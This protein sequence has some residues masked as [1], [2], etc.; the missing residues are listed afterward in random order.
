MANAKNEYLLQYDYLCRNGG[1]FIKKNVEMADSSMK[2]LSVEALIPGGNQYAGFLPLRMEEISF[3]PSGETYRYKLGGEYYAK[4]VV[5]DL[6]AWK[7]SLKD[8]NR[9][10]ALSGVEAQDALPTFH[11]SEKCDHTL[12]VFLKGCICFVD[13]LSGAVIRKI[14]IGDDW[15]NFLFNE[16]KGLFSFTSGNALH[17][18]DYEGKTQLVYR[19]EC[20]DVLSGAVPSRDEFGIGQGAYW[21]PDGGKLAFYIVDQSKISAYPLVRIQDPVAELEMIKYPV[22]GSKSETVRLAVY[23]LATGTIVRL[24]PSEW[25]ESY[26]TCV[27]W[28]PD[29]GHLYSMEVHRSQKYCRLRSYSAVNGQLE[30]TLFDEKDDKYVEPQH[31]LFFLPDG[32]FVWQSRR[33]GYNHLYL[34][35]ATG[36]LVRQLTKGSFEV[37]KLCGYLDE[38]DELLLLSTFSS[39]LNRDLCAVRVSDASFRRISKDGGT[40]SVAVSPKSGYFIDSFSSSE[41][42]GCAVLRNL[43]G[44]NGRLLN[45]AANPYE[46]YE[47]PVVEIGSFERGGDEI[48]YRIV[49][50]SRMEHGKRYPLAYYVYGG[51]HVQLIRNEWGAGMKGFEQM[52]ALN[53]YVVMSIDPHGSDNRGKAFEQRIWRNIGAVQMED[54]RYS[55]EW[56]LRK[57]SYVDSNRMG[58]YGWSFGGFMAMRLMLR[59][60]WLFALGVAGGPVV[61]WSFYE[62]MYTERYMGKPTEN[63]DGFAENNM[64]RYVENLSGDLLLVHCDNDPVVLWQNTLSFLQAAVSA[65]RQVDYAV[66]PG[67]KHNVQGPDRVHLML[68]IKHYFD[69]HFI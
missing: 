51:P 49:R 15:K 48:F 68:K 32:H 43:K 14:N 55:I 60:P 69:R 31:P 12:Y 56:L 19:E 33:D 22:A 42:P 3:L 37:T 58:V 18:L 34:Y 16:E 11:F 26:L 29:A 23:D 2:Q 50:P 64:R 10:L 52:M 1:G 67:H 8:F 65:A 30:R 38:T 7:V 59:S 27:T 47:V 39:P 9:M 5:G 20:A 45:R 6:S 63:P 36:R 24:A 21:S 66:Y 46:G 62:V 28:S 61:D 4:S 35:N 13:L 54:Y 41:N 17:L 53:D 44:G 57:R 40:H 25:E